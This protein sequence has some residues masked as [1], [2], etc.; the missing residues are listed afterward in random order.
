MFII[1]RSWK[2]LNVLK[3]TYANVLLLI[4]LKTFEAVWQVSLQINVW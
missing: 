2:I 3:G 1:E 4:D